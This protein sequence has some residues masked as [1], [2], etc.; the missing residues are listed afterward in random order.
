MH[1]AE[2]PV[3]P[4]AHVAADGVKVPLPVD[5]QLIDPVGVVGVPPEASVTVAV[6]V[7]APD[8]PIGLGAHTTV[9]V[10]VRCVTVSVADV[11]LAWWVASPP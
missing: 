11:L 2:V 9:V 3:P 1:E 4:R 5:V 10:V 6:H 7:V 8:T